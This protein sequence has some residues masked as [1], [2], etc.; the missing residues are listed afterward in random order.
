M[1]VDLPTGIKQGA[2]STLERS[3]AAPSRAGDERTGRLIQPVMFLAGTTCAG[4]DV[5]TAGVAAE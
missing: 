2:A 1:S 3:N 5:V 4:L